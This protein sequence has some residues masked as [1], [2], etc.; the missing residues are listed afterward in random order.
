MWNVSYH[1][2]VK[3]LMDK[4]SGQFLGFAYI[5]FAK[6]ES[7]QFAVEKMNGKVQCNSCNNLPTILVTW[8]SF[9]FFIYIK[10]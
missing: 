6:E 4:E 2:A 10:V 9:F 5:F 3:L 8:K 7:A 1:I